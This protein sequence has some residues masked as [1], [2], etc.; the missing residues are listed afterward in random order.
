LR[1]IGA[2]R[3]REV[4]RFW[5][6]KSRIVS[7]LIMPLLWLLIFGS[8]MRNIQIPGIDNYQMYI[9]P[10]VLGMSTLFTSIWSGI[11]VIWDREFGFL[12][13][14]LVAPVPRASYSDRQSIRRRN[15]RLS[16]GIHPAAAVISGRN[17]AGSTFFPALNTGYD[18]PVNWPGLRGAIDRVTYEQYG[19]L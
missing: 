13:E 1:K 9:F 2:L 16:A 10:G 18:S 5:R 8:G 7:S 19:G 12:K 15:Q 17:Q 6:E 11:S 14:L 3:Y 4:L